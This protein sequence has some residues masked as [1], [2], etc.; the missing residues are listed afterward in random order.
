MKKTNMT[1]KNTQSK[2][3]TLVELMV[4]VAII[5]ILAVIGLTVFSNAQRSSRDAK[6][7]SDVAAIANSM[8]VHLSTAAGQCKGAIANNAVFSDQ[9]GG[10][11]GGVAGNYCPTQAAWFAGSLVPLDPINAVSGGVTYTYTETGGALP[12]TAFKVCA[13][14]EG[15]PGVPFC[16][17]NQQ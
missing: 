10:A 2:G 16:L 6:R 1:T 11:V 8:E 12:G 3:F 4:V 13:N 14:L 15:T 7:Q 5:A 17:S 9:T